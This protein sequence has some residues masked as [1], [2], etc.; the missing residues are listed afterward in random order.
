MNAQV[1]SNTV[2]IEI[3]GKPV[4]V[5]KGSMIIEAADR[6][7]IDIPRFCYHRKLSIAANCR[8]CLVDVEK[9]PKP[10]PAC[11]TPVA[12]GMKVFT[13]SCRARDAQKNVMEFLL[14]NHPLDC[15]ICDQGGECELQDL[16]MGYG[17]SV[18]RF[19]ERKRSVKDKNIGPLIS[20]EMT[21]CIHC[22]RCVRFLDEI[23]GSN[24]LGTIGRGE[25]TEIST[26]IE[27]SIASELSGNIIDLCPVGALTDKPFRFRARAWE[28]LARPALAMH[29]CLHS[30]VWYHT[31]R[32]ELMRAVPR[33][34][35][36]V[37][38]TWLADRD[39]YSHLG[40]YDQQRL[41]Q[42][43]LRQDGRW[44]QVSWEQ[45]LHSAAEAMQAAGP[46]LQIM[47]SPQLLGEEHLAFVQL[48]NLQGGQIDYRLYTDDAQAQS[49]SHGNL[50]LAALDEC[51]AGLL[52]GGR[53]HHDQ[54]LLAHRLR[55]AQ[56]RHGA[57]LASITAVDVDW[58]CKLEHKLISAPDRW[59]QELAGI[60]LALQ[61]DY[62]DKTG[63]KS[64][65]KAIKVTP[66]HEQ[67]AARL[68][69][70]ERSVVIAAQQLAMHPQAALLQYLMRLI[71]EAS[72]SSLMVLTAGS[73]TAAAELLHAHAAT[74][75][76]QGLQQL[77]D[78][79]ARV[80]LL[81]SL[82]PLL[83]TVRPD[84]LRQAC[85][86]AD[87]VIALTAFEHEHLQQLADI[88]LPV[89]HALETGGTAINIDGQ[90]HDF[91][92]VGKLSGAARPG[93]KVARML[94]DL[95]H[96]DGDDTQTSATGLRQWNDAQSVS[97]ELA[98]V[99]KQIADAD[100]AAAGCLQQ[101]PQKP[102]S[103]SAAKARSSKQLS[104]ISELPMVRVDQLCRHSKPLGDSV[105]Q[106]Q[107]R[108]VLVHPQ[109]LRKLKLNDQD[110]VLVVQ[111]DLQ[112]KARIIA[113][114]R[115]APGCAWIALTTALAAELGAAFGAVTVQ[116]LPADHN[117]DD[118]HGEQQ[119]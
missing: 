42:P 12:D 48:A 56:R 117:L 36:S 93:W 6:I 109:E 87:V 49:W 31:R 101:L 64:L 58:Y 82:D 25:K 59:L 11:A 86:Q 77:V 81:H 45:A 110:A 115:I 20:T 103:L 97:T 91:A 4:E 24:E 40:L 34:H 8:M 71:A 94:A 29:D 111:G 112:A 104:R 37:N 72:N 105:H 7:G 98:A 46:D 26:Y 63:F 107:E 69:A 15:P 95:L 62:A 66:E 90:Q 47:L 14:I 17:R 28:M 89:A 22:T 1:Q 52:V 5:A 79:P 61:P 30:H 118:A 68:S 50:P 16:A 119:K 23:A 43:Q 35:E 96:A 3:D 19:T 13:E 2:T 108:E 54:P 55:Q 39:R 57:S 51:D 9:A 83:D 80:L 65:L 106:V 44:Q 74:N 100:N 38:E 70:G 113:D 41:L 78:R 67:I 75:R 84:L 32:G 114:Q 102:S 53:I 116:S 92:A 10:L 60:L 21:R 99:L 27:K 76:M 88:V 73:N 18:S 85:E 33:D